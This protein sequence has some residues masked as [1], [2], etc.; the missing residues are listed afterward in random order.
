MQVNTQM[1]N[2]LNGDYMSKIKRPPMVAKLKQRLKDNP[3]VRLCDFNIPLSNGQPTPRLKDILEENV[4]EKY[5]LRN[6]IVQ[7]I[8]EEADFKER[9]VSITLEKKDEL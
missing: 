3:K 5:Y 4:D 7:K 9:L 8:V 6:E 2:E 1:E